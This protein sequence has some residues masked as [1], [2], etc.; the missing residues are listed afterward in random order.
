M[1]SITWHELGIGGTCTVIGDKHSIYVLYSA[2]LQLNSSS[3][4][5]NWISNIHV[6][7]VTTGIESNLSKLHEI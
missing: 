2:L 6:Y 7:N 4:H 3:V 5:D 1:F